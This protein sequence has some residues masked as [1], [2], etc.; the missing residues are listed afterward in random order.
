VQNR[1]INDTYLTLPPGWASSYTCPMLR[2]LVQPNAH[3][4]M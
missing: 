2:P 3:P 4:R 1:N